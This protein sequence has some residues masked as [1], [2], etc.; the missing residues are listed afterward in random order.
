MNYITCDLFSICSIAGSTCSYLL[1]ACNNIDTLCL[2]VSILHVP[3]PP[4]TDYERSRDRR[5][6]ANVKKMQEMGLRTLVADFKNSIPQPETTKGG[7]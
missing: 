4:M 6:E 3:Q 5:I 7:N 2:F 1:A